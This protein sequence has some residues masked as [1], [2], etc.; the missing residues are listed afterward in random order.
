MGWRR[1]VWIISKQMADLQFLDMR[2][3][4]HLCLFRD[5]EDFRRNIID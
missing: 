1:V 4:T 5:M 3:S 2:D